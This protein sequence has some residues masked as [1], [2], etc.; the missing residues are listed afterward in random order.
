M[1]TWTRL[2]PAVLLTLPYLG[3]TLHAGDA[4]TNAEKISQLQKDVAKL[5]KEIAELRKDVNDNALRRNASAEELGKMRE[6]LERM[7]L[8]QGAIQHRVSAYGPQAVASNAPPQTSATITVEN[9]FLADAQ[10]SINGQLYTVRP[11]QTIQVPRIQVG[12][13]EYFVEV[14]GALIQ[15]PRL[16]TLPPPGY[17]IRIYRRM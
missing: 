6:L 5:Q 11:G 10:V 2:F 17:V 13:F 7:A 3:T 9:Q 14:N 4:E 12:P 15:P 1:R 8:Q 16:E